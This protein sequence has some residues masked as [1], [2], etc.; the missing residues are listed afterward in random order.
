MRRGHGTRRSSSSR[1]VFSKQRYGG[2]AAP[3]AEPVVTQTAQTATSAPRMDVGAG[4]KAKPPS[5]AIGL[6]AGGGGVGCL[7]GAWATG[8][9]ASNPELTLAPTV[10][11]RARAAQTTEPTIPKLPLCQALP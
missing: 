9:Q 1:R 11:S 7:A 2:G 8:Q 6:L 10:L 3:V 4:G 5:L